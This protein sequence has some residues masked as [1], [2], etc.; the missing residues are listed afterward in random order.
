MNSFFSAN[1]CLALGRLLKIVHNN[2]NKYLSTESSYLNYE[3]TTSL[4]GRSRT[5][6]ASSDT[7]LLIE[8]LGC[9]RCKNWTTSVS[10]QSVSVNISISWVICV[11]LWFWRALGRN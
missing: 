5:C 4:I 1:C 3:L 8:W 9:V 11:C 6:M 7:I 2:I 10:R